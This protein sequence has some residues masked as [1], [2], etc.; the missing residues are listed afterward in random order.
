MYVFGGHSGMIGLD[1]TYA[2]AFTDAWFSRDNGKTWITLTANLDKNMKSRI[3]LEMVGATEKPPSPGPNHGWSFATLSDDTIFMFGGHLHTQELVVSQEMWKTKALSPDTKAPLHPLLYDPPHDVGAAAPGAGT[4]VLNTKIRLVFNE[5]IKR[6]GDNP[7][8]QEELSFA[9]QVDKRLKGIH[10]LIGESDAAVPASGSV[11]IHRGTLTVTL[12]S[13]LPA[14]KL[15]EVTI[16]QGYL[17]DISDNVYV[18]FPAYQFRT[19]NDTTKPNPTC[20]F[21]ETIMGKVVPYTSVIFQ[22]EE[23]FT[24]VAGEF[25]FTPK[26]ESGRK[27]T[28]S[29]SERE[30]RLCSTGACISP[31]EV[32]DSAYSVANNVFISLDSPDN[33]LTEGM[34]Y[35]AHIPQGAFMDSS[36]QLSDEIVCTFETMSG[37]GATNRNAPEDHHDT[38]GNVY[39]DWGGSEQMEVLATNGDIVAPSMSSISPTA[40]CFDCFVRHGGDLNGG[41][42]IIIDFD[43]GVEINPEIAGAVEIHYFDETNDPAEADHDEANGQF[44]LYGNDIVTHTSSQAHSDPGGDQNL[45]DITIQVFGQKVYIYVDNFDFS[46]ESGDPTHLRGAFYMTMPDC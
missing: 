44:D 26:Y 40:G 3:P 30:V 43:E 10:V 13:P 9:L 32:L 22:F 7:T 33:Y 31:G 25:T 17:S 19:V 27:L 5:H 29:Y 36:G 20:I 2:Q 4:A 6:L 46:D 45:K 37:N 38:E 15:V 8:K 21:Q 35:T 39:I 1:Y 16:S 34:E 12:D 14:D 24:F 42:Y 23:E 28:F 18:D 11:N 41:N